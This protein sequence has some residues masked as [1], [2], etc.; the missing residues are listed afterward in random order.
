MI[1]HHD[2][3]FVECRWW[4]DGV[5]V[6][7]RHSTVVGLHYTGP[8]CHLTV[9]GL[10]DTGSRCSTPRWPCA[11]ASASRGGDMRIDPLF[12]RSRHTSDFKTG[13]LVA[14]LPGAWRDWVQSWRRSVS[15]Q[16]QYTD[17]GWPGICILGEKV[18]L[19]FNCCRS[20]YTCLSKSVPEIALHVAVALS[21]QETATST[22]NSCVQRKNNLTVTLR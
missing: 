15:V 17:T 13:K 8:R 3:Q 19:V 1:T 10:H 20:T 2:T 5:T 7:T 12:S 6:K 21:F 18:C 16:S 22:A 11:K 4:N 14:T 9:V